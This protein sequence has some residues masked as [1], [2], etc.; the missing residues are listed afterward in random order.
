M[1][2]LLVLAAAFTGSLAGFLAVNR[3][4]R[5]RLGTACHQV[6]TGLTAAVV[7]LAAIAAAATNATQNLLDLGLP[8]TTVDVLE[9]ASYFVF[10]FAITAAWM[11]MKPSTL[12]WFLAALVPVALFEPLRWAFR[13]IA[14]SIKRLGLW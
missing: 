14:W 9:A 1:S 11:L 5:G 3:F 7:L 12:R 13:L 4:G 10:G 8:F 2:I 6:K